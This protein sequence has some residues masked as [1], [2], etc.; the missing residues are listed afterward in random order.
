MK[1]F[2]V[3]GICVPEQHYMVDITAKLIEIKKLI[4][5]GA[6]FTINR[7]RQFGKTTTLSML[8]KYIQNEYTVIRISFEGT[9]EKKFESEENFC[10]TFFKTL[11]DSCRFSNKKLAN[12]IL[13]MDKSFDTFEN[14]SSGISDLCIKIGNPL[15]LMIDEVDKNCKNK[16]FL[17]FLSILRNKYLAK[18]E[19]IDISF[20]SVILAGVYDIK[21]LK[22]S[23]RSNDEAKYNSPWNIAADFPIDMSFNKNEITSMLIDYKNETHININ[24]NELSEEIYRYSSGYP[25]LVSRICK[26]IDEQLNKNWSTDGVKSAVNRILLEKSTLMDDLNKNM[27]NNNKLHDLVYSLLINGKSIFYNNDNESIRLAEI[28][29]IIKIAENDRIE[30]HNIIFE[31]RIYNFLL[32][33]IELN[34]R[35]S[36]FNTEDNQFLDKN[37][38][39]N[40][41][42]ILIKFQEVMYEQHKHS[43]DKFIEDNGRLLFILFLKPIINGKGF[44]F[45]EP[46]TRNNKR[47]DLV[48]TYNQKLYIIELKIWH[49]AKYDNA[50]L[51]QLSNYLDIQHQN[52]GY[53]VT[54]N[55][56]KNKESKNQWL[57][58]EGKQIF[59]ICI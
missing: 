5:E 16:V 34:K 18:Q 57:D 6:Y 49:G 26:I 41:E 37:C 15:V 19:G 47:M 39:L 20:H 36:E 22:L 43:Y 31:K 54:F 3:T 11:Y 56:N 40:M 13:N 45:V 9:G 35:V 1:K 30:I 33:E 53:L 42:Q 7:A 51:K 25:Y 50:G 24:I 10:K 48:I 38:D 58:V 27:V 46:R 2:N 8:S 21:N 55:F 4:D 14:L 12:T 32:S 52:I 28:F 44:Y 59:S 23:L 29:S 17:D